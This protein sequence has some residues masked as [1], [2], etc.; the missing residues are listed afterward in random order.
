M[1]R[2]AKF[3]YIHEKGQA[4]SIYSRRLRAPCIEI[5]KGACYNHL[6]SR[7]VGDRGLIL[8]MRYCR[9]EWVK[10]MR[11]NDTRTGDTLNLIAIL[12][13]CFFAGTGNY[14]NAAVHTFQQAFPA[15]S[16]SSVMLVSTLPG[17]IAVPVM[18]LAGRL[19]GRRVTYR[20]ICILGTV[21]ILT[22]GLLPV[23]LPANWT[24]ILI[25]RAILGVGAGCYGVRNS[26]II[27]SVPPEKAAALTGY[28]TV[29][30]TAGGS[31]SGVIVGALAL[32]GW[33]F[34]F[35]YNLFPFFILF[36]VV[37]GLREPPT[38]LPAA[39]EA[40]GPFGSGKLSWRIWFYALTQFLIIVSL[41]P[42]TISGVSIFFAAYGLGSSAIAGAVMSLFP[43]SGVVGNLFLDRI[44]GR[45]RRHTIPV[46]TLVVISSVIL[47]LAFHTMPAVAAS[48]ILA[49]FGY[50]IIIGTLQVY[51][52]LEAPP[53]RTA[54][55]S[56]MILA[57]KSVGIFLSG[58]FITLCDAVF[59]LRDRISLENSFLG[60]LFVYLALLAFSVIVD[61][62]PKGQ[63]VK[64]G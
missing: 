32:G 39:S 7:A 52:G 49:G 15:I 57:G 28:S 17:L 35:L 38:P 6:D 50:H 10:H 22:G 29:A 8:P 62:S 43:L 20:R 44:L 18:L 40:S 48:Y 4:G 31:V 54:A 3:K 30:L 63:E 26:F 47:C 16:Q 59:H 37:F 1:E 64:N 23:V 46:M 2:K 61:V 34:A 12:A 33:R 5:G 36:L 55:G 13:I 45:L 56:T 21:M 24:L 27:R 60:C 25:C 53:D 58:Y 51:N 11:N 14:M 41:Y 9:P 19:V 42:M